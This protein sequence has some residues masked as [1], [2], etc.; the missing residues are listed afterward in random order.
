MNGSCSD[1]ATPIIAGRKKV[2]LSPEWNE[3]LET[4]R[5]NVTPQALVNAVLLFCIVACLLGLLNVILLLCFASQAFFWDWSIGFVG[6]L[7]TAVSIATGVSCLAFAVSAV[8]IPGAA[9]GAGKACLGSVAAT[10]VLTG[11]K[12][13]IQ[14]EKVH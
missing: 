10:A 14:N 1:P 11:L 13:V 5:N 12:A 2:V 3:I 9:V 6:V 8:V 4:L 7:V